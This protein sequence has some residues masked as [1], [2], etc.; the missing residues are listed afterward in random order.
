VLEEVIKALEEDIQ[1]GR[2]ILLKVLEMATR[3]YDAWGAEDD[4]R[5]EDE[6]DP[7]VKE[8]RRFCGIGSSQMLGFQCSCSS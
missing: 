1:R 3:P 5:P 2:P 7:E 8:E 4:A 6:L